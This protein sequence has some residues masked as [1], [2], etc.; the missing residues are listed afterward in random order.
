MT[1][2]SFISRY[3]APGFINYSEKE[4]FSCRLVTETIE[5]I[6]RDYGD[7]PG[8][9][10]IKKWGPDYVEY[11][12]LEYDQ[13]LWNYRQTDG[14]LEYASVAKTNKSNSL[15]VVRIG[16]EKSYA[17][18]L[19]LKR[20]RFRAVDVWGDTG[21][22][23]GSFE[24]PVSELPPVFLGFLGSVLDDCTAQGIMTL[25]EK[26]GWLNIIFKLSREYGRND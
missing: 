10:W 19:D 18:V 3:S 24:L 15:V 17:A 7:Y 11:T 8:Q 12:D 26:D 21:S 22:Y 13:G 2:H 9:R 6:Y 20:H 1:I 23:Y 4:T 16:N 14:T 25:E 5:N